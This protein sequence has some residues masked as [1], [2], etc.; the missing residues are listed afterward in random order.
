MSAY[1]SAFKTIGKVLKGNKSKVSPK[2][3]SVKLNVPKTNLE[4][5]KSKLAIAKQKTKAS[6]AK[7]KTN[8]V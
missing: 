1:F 8:F 5:A 4:K 6:A 3:K 2:I 7:T